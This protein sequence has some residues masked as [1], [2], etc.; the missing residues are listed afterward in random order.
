[1]RRLNRLIA[2]CVGA[3]LLAAPA[4]WACGELGAMT[5]QCPMTAMQGSTGTSMCHDGG[6]M[7]EDCCDFASASEPMQAL[8]VDNAKLLM[9]PEVTD[10]RVVAPLAPAALPPHSADALRPPDLGRYTLFSSFL[11]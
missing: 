11:L 7:S 5:P 8:S 9:A 4:A 1:M 3:L 2:L 10:L 6:R